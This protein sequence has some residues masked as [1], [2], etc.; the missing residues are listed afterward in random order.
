MTVFDFW[1]THLLL[2]EL[3]LAAVCAGAAAIYLFV[4]AEPSVADSPIFGNRETVYQASV[5]VGATLA[6]FVG[7]VVAIVSGL[8][9]TER[10][11]L[12]RESAHRETLWK[13]F[14]STMRCLGLLVIV[15]FVGLIV[16]H[17]CDPV[18]GIAVAFLY[19]ALLSVFRM[20]RSIWLL[21]RI[22]RIM[23]MPSPSNRRAG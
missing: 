15:S 4:L 13:V 14:F 8:I 22:V 12:L 3:A 9:S 5:T 2:A 6:G 10:L 23:A 16:D 7:T 20:A 1:R 11:Q 19:S 21:Q 17:R 18:M